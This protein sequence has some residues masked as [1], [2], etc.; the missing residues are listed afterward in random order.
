MC[1]CLN[2]SR[3][4][5]F[6]DSCFRDDWVGTVISGSGFISTIISEICWVS[7]IVLNCEI[8][9]KSEQ[10]TAIFRLY[11]QDLSVNKKIMIIILPETRL[12][13]LSSCK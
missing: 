13:D 5:V 12:A 1:S 8:E 7:F 9:S 10:K 4:D 6:Y 3:D 11:R 2:I